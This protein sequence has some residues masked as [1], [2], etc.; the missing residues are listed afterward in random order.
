MNIL[1][2]IALARHGGWASLGKII[3]V[4]GVKIYLINMKGE[5]Y[6]VSVKCEHLKGSFFLP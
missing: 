5:I 4:E 2:K 6:V 3:N 1:R